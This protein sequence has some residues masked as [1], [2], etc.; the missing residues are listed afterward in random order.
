MLLKGHGLSLNYPD[1]G[2][3][4]NGDIDIYLFG[5]W[6]EADQFARQ[7]FGCKIE[8][9]IGHHTVFEWEDTTVEN[10]Y[11]FLNIRYRR[12]YQELEPEL[13]Q[14]A[15]DRSHSVEIDGQ[16]IYL[17]SPNL[18]ALFL[19][20]HTSN[21]FPPNGISLRHV[22]DWAFFVEKQGTQV[23]WGWLMD[24]A[25]H[26]NMHRFLA[27]INR[28]AVDF[29]GFSPSIFPV[30]ECDSELADKCLEDIFEY[31]QEEFNE[32]FLQKIKRWIFPN[33]KYKICFND[34]HLT[35]VFNYFWK[36]FLPRYLKLRL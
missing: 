20:R 7:E 32:T 13:K 27:C 5:K 18:N 33:W 4:P 10:H 15:E 31:S 36:N 1:P 9:D 30:M 35:Y 21:H 34:I 2:L 25:R 17:P 22:L 12:S 3:R 11:N 14:L 16:T 28:I 24:R 19:L 26:Y 29:L 6:K 23:D 8:N